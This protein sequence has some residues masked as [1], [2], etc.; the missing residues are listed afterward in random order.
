MSLVMAEYFNEALKGS[1]PGDQ[2]LKDLQGELQN[3][4]DQT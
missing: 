3:V 1:T 4:V 2:A